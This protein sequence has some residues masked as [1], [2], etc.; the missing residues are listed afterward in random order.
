MKKA[1]KGTIVLFAAGSLALSAADT[2]ATVNGHEI[3][4]EDA[5]RFIQASQPTL[6]YD[7][8]DEKQ[9]KQIEER[10]IERELFAEEA[11]KAGIEKDPDFIRE[12]NKVKKDIMIRVWMQKQY[13]KMIV[14]DSEA[15]DF[16]DKNRDK[17][18]IP[19]RVHARHILLK[20]E[21][22]AKRVIS[23]LKGL[24]GE[25]L[26]KRFIELAKSESKGPTA[27]KGGDLGYFSQG[28]MVLPFSRAAFSLKKGEITKKP[29]KTQFGYHVI[30]VED[31]KEA[32]TLPFESVKEKIIA[33]L[34]EKEFADKMELRMSELK[35][36]A[37]IER[38]R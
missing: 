37:K 20:D 25:E 11:Q 12:L 28:Q 35:K 4:V 2:L 8:L 13:K 16:Y 36:E 31:V 22:S 23:Q 10:L 30:Y 38:K 1:I 34:K 7:K 17:F 6:D 9:K 15:R 27:V 19:A 24:R 26:K 14:S 21:D 29:V 18:A 33:K 5:N 3:S 32:E